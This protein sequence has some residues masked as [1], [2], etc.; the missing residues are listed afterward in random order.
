MFIESSAGLKVYARPVYLAKSK[1]K[2]EIKTDAP[3]VIRMGK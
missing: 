3:K 1:K 2:K